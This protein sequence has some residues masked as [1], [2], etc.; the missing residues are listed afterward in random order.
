MHILIT[1]KIFTEKPNKNNSSMKKILSVVF[2]FFISYFAVSAETE[3]KNTFYCCQ[4]GIATQQD[5]INNLSMFG[6]SKN[7]LLIDREHILLKD[8]PD[9]YIHETSGTQFDIICFSFESGKLNSVDLQKHYQINEKDRAKRDYELFCSKF[10]KEYGRY[11]FFSPSDL[12][13]YWGHNSSTTL[14]LQF[15][16]FDGWNQKTHSNLEDFISIQLSYKLN[17]IGKEKIIS[18]IECPISNFKLGKTRLKGFLKE[19]EKQGLTIIQ[20]SDSCYLITDVTVD[21]LN[22]DVCAFNFSNSVL[23]NVKLINF[24][25]IQKNKNEG[26]LVDAYVYLEELL[27]RRYGRSGESIIDYYDSWGLPYKYWVNDKNRALQY[28]Y[29]ITHN[30]NFCITI[31]YLIK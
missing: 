1:D 25:S 30:N 7:D 13:A 27:N 2:L 9:I 10:N 14:V 15:F 8:K 29:L 31:E 20:K 24:Y 17:Y 5:V 18:K 28:S 16:D 23:N 19:V 21:K 26:D 12:A 3:I 6:Y 4:L 11:D 22:F